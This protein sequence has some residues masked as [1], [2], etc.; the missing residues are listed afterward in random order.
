MNQALAQLNRAATTE[1]VAT[2]LDC[3]HSRRWAEALAGSR[4]YAS[5]EALLRV[6]EDAWQL[7]GQSDWLEAFA[8]HPKIGDIHSLRKKYAST[9]AMAA[10]EQGGVKAADERTLEELARL[11]QIYLEK[12]G[13]IFIVF[14]TG[15]SAAEM[16]AILQSRVNNSREAELRNAAA[17]QK[18]ITR[19]RLERLLCLA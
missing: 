7:L 4:P 16:L 15:K 10:N 5:P 14:A 8:A 11:N 2:F 3:C 12:F 9:A 6:S 13:F 1:A 19:L 18:K 17:E